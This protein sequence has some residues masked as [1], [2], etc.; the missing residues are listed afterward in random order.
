MLHGIKSNFLTEGTRSIAARATA[1]IGIVGT[2]PAAT[3]L[4]FPLGERVLI[5]DIRAA[6]A[7]MGDTGTLPA[8]MAAI[9]DQASPIVVLVRVGVDA[10]VADQNALVNAGLDLL[11]SAESEFDARPKIIGAPGLDTAIVTAHMVG[12][13]QKLRGFTY[14]AAIGATAQDAIDYRA[15]FGQRELMLIWPNFT[16]GFAGDAVARAMGLRAQID[17]QQG[18]HKTLSNVVVNGVTGIDTD[19]TFDFQ[20]EATDAALLNTAGVTTLVRFGGGFRFWGNRTCSDE[21]L[22]A[23]ESAVRSSQVLADEIAYGLAWATDK[24]MN[25]Y[26][27]KDVVETVNARLRKLVSQGRLIGAKA[28]FDP[29]LNPSADLAAGKLVLDYDFTAVAPLEGLE[30]NQ[31]ITDRYYADLGAQLAA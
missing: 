2:A 15:D 10:D 26:L 30:L 5:T 17:E 22:Y 7:D 3:A 11:L 23:F 25:R 20:S 1:V 6:L 27:V 16:G 18:W 29:A 19:V 21:P 28:W 12:V 4:K 24:P 14:A 13:T 9:A 31:R 8:A